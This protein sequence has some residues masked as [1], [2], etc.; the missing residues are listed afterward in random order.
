MKK[1]LFFAILLMG[2]Y[3]CE[4]E[5]TVIENDVYHTEALNEFETNLSNRSSWPKTAW[6]LKDYLNDRNFTHGRYVDCN[7]DLV[8]V[9]FSGGNSTNVD[10][11]YGP[12]SARPHEETYTTSD[13]FKIVQTLWE[14]V[15]NECSDAVIV[16]VTFDVG[17]FTPNGD[18]D[19]YIDAEVTICCDPNISPYTP[20][21][22][23]PKEEEHKV[24]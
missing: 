18:Y 7:E 21:T 14:K 15:R 2:L 20:P 19:Y 13:Y 1:I 17:F 8:T 3:S 23:E 9:S 4:K 6:E 12:L 24:E 10:D 5:T 22:P 16:D 11:Q